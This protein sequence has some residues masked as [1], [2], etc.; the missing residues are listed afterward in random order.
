[1]C[2]IFGIIGKTRNP[3][4]ALVERLTDAVS[5]RGPDG[6]GALVRGAVGLGHRRLSII[7]LSD[8]ALQPMKHH[9]EPLWLVFNGEI[10][11]YIELRD[12][13]R[14]LGHVFHTASDTEVILASYLQ[15]GEVCLNRFNGMWS[16]ALLDERKQELFCAR[17]RF[18]VKPFYWTENSQ[19]FAF[20]SEIRQLLPLLP[21][22]HTQHAMLR[23]FLI[24]GIS[25][26]TQDTFFR[27]ITKLMPGHW[28]KYSLQSHT[29]QVRRYY[30]LQP[31]VSAPSDANDS[32]QQLKELLRSA[33]K[34]RLRSDVR[35]GTCLSGGLD[36]SSVATLA[37]QLHSAASSEPF[38]AITAVSE[39][40]SNNEAEFAQEIVRRN[41]LKWLTTQ[42][43]YDDF[44]A[45][46]QDVITAQEEPYGGPS[47]TMQYFVMKAARANGVTV[48]LDG[49]GGDE[50]LLGYERYYAAWLRNRLRQGV[51]SLLSGVSSASRNN[52]NVSP[53]ILA[54]Y[55]LGGN[56]AALR[57][58]F[59]RNRLSFLTGNM[60]LPE[61]L[62]RFAAANKDAT[63]LQTLEITQ[64]N[65]PML[66]RFED[67]N[68][69]RHGIE[70]RL[71]FLDYRLVEFAL[72]LPLDVKM[73]DGWT[74]WPLRQAMSTDM[75]DTIT[76]RKNKFGFEAPDALWLERHRMAMWQAVESSALLCEHVSVRALAP[77]FATLD[78]KVAWRLYCVALWERAFGVNA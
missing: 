35:V 51:G 41:G 72:A 34:L 36:S 74:K 5:H 46:L 31:T 78:R 10:Y 69:M 37:A 76:W 53:A 23:D 50:T 59:Y 16:F 1:M 57:E 64:T 29:H 68:S 58:M 54:K 65:L 32:A 49:Q 52:I 45:T 73:H 61:A 7:D 9:S 40:Q 56:F 43:G 28:L 66:L 8:E 27:G 18:G 42:P 20:G 26:H 77:K 13:L 15:W 67:K 3:D 38:H 48:L 39:Q 17:D 19:H 60:T 2:G 33:V 44:C 75:P 62:R 6:R 71:P 12:E 14:A 30:T 47:I 63:A 11:N 22:A 25:D 24:C 70:A 55:Y 4:V 21:A